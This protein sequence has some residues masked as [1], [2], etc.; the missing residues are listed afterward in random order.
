M[1]DMEGYPVI[2]P[3]PRMLNHAT[4]GLPGLGAD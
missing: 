3:K 4:E 1:L 2:D